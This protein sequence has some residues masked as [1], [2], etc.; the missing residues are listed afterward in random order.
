MKRIDD[1]EY[2]IWGQGPYDK[3]GICVPEP[4]GADLYGAYVQYLQY[5][6]TV[7][8]ATSCLHFTKIFKANFSRSSSVLHG[9]SLEICLEASMLVMISS[10]SARSAR[11]DTLGRGLR[12]SSRPWELALIRWRSNLISYLIE[13]NVLDLVC[14]IDSAA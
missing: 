10:K 12:S 2:G 7:H 13:D 5:K 3:Y 4:Y 8:T 9:H 6:A 1:D 11:I 14:D